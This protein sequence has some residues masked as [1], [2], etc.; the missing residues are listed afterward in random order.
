[1]SFKDTRS[2]PPSYEA[3]PEDEEHLPLYGGFEHEQVDQNTLPASKASPDEV[4]QFIMHILVSRRQLP[5]DHVRRVAARWTVG[6]GLEL[7]TYSPSMY[8]ELFGSEDGWILYK[9]VKLMMHAESR[10][11][12]INRYGPDIFLAVLSSFFITSVVLVVLHKEQVSTVLGIFGIIGGGMV[13][14]I[15]LLV[16]CLGPSPEQTVVNELR[17]ASERASSRTN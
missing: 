14:M 10:K 7:R 16:R 4:R 11:K 1:M 9:E 6:S 5:T 8:L 3:P 2:E 17:H 13:L 15:T 12:P